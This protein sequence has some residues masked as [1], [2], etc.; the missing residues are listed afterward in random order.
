MCDYSDHSDYK[1]PHESLEDSD[2]CIFHLKDDN[3]NVDVFN[4]GINELLETEEDS[5][6]FRGFY[7][8]LGTSDF[9]NRIFQK[10]VNFMGVK[11]SDNADF[12]RAEF[13]D[14]A[15]FEEAKFLSD[16]VFWR[17]EFS[18]NADFKKAEFSGEADFMDA[19]FLGDT[20]FM[21]AEFSDKV[22]FLGANFLGEAI[23]WSTNFLGEAVFKGSEFLDKAVFKGSEFSDKAVF[24]VAKFSEVNFHG[25]EFLGK[26][27]IVLNEPETVP[28]IYFTDTLFSDCVRIKG[29]LSQCYF[30]N[31]NIEIADL[32]DSTWIT[33]KEKRIIIWEE[34]QGEISSD[35]KELEGIYRRL[36]Q[37]YQKHGDND[38]AGNFYYQEMECKRKQMKFSQKLFWNIFYKKLCG[39]GEKPFNVIL[40]SLFIIFIS[41]FSYLFSGIEF[42]GSEISNKPAKLIKYNLN[43]SSDGINMMMQN[44]GSILEDFLL[45]LY[46]SFITFTTLGYGDVHPIGWSRLVATIESG[47]GIFMTALFI[48]VF[49]RK[50]LR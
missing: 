9:S 34:H 21:N 32:T 42:L 16:A 12:L 48:F 3:K 46:T 19:K 22:S 35:W 25:T 14:K 2:Y 36:K 5:I 7:F 17:A 13:T 1:C 33:N 43:L 37:S 49:T 50:M 28:T 45:C 31:S 26:L 41:A 15:V 6:D 29:N 18:G 38:T 40:S 20:D 47:F 27:F 24:E 10:S 39:Y 30:H 8:P 44:F 4:Y 11:F 23:F